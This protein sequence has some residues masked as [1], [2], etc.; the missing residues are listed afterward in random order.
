MDDYVNLL[1]F[2]YYKTIIIVDSCYVVTE[3]LFFS[4]LPI[5]TDGFLFLI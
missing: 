5:S 3:Y 1:H 4:V 2:N